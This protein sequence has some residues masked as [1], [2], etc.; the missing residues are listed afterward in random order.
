MH[1]ELAS[2]FALSNRVSFITGAASGIGREIA[3]AFALAGAIPILAD[4][5]QDGLLKTADIVAAAGAQTEVH[6]LDVAD[7]EAVDRV[8]DSVFS[9]FGQLDVWVNCAGVIVG[10]SVIDAREEEVERLIA[11]NLKGTY[12]GCSAAGR[13]MCKRRS[14]SIINF[15]S[16]GADVPAPGLSIYAMTK[17]AVNML[18]RTVATEL[19]P[20]GIRANA[21]A[22]GWVETPIA[23]HS[24][25]DADG[26]I[27][28]AKREKLIRDRASGSPLG[29]AGTP[30][31][32]AMTA[33]YLA[34]DASRFMTGQVLRPN[35]GVAMP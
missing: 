3:R 29:I 8:A 13:V 30:Q 1:A 34:A 20:F 16:A 27:D 19:G 14:G 28:P 33:L 2:A 17:A 11:V 7:R 15:S 5:D 18:T 26:E 9:R 6:R 22:P 35:G 32:I 25:R 24:I 10:R 4:V 21:I 12:W 31:D 23:L